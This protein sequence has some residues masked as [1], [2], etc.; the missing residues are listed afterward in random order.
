MYE[1]NTKILEL[2]WIFWSF[3]LKSFFEVFKEF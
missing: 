3:G 1:W 2:F